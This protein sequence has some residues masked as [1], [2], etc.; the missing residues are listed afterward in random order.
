MSTVH[1]HSDEELFAL[2]QKDSHVAYK[3]IYQRYS[4]L[5]YLH[6]YKKLGERELARDFTQDL[7]TTLWVKRSETT[8]KTV[9]SSYLYTAM[10]N[11]VLDYFA[12]KNLQSNYISFVEN[13]T[14]HE[15][16]VTDHLIRQKQ[17]MQMIEDEIAALP[18]KMREVFKMSRM[19]HLTH[20]EIAVKL[21]ISEQTVRKQIQNALKIMRPKLRIL[22][23]FY[24]LT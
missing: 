15:N 13:Y 16:D 18:R 11:R 6:A 2:L 7:L 10:R 9:L 4:R 24:F 21:A 1:H 22:L 23:A 14:F 5:L 8:I 12:H 19:Q 20:R 3:E 17:L